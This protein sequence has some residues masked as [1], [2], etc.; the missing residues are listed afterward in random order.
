MEEIKSDPTIDN[1]TLENVKKIMSE[2][3]N[4][5]LYYFGTALDV[6][7]HYFF[8]LENDRMNNK[9]LSFPKGGGLSILR[10]KEW[11]FEPEEY[12]K[13]RHNGDAEFYQISGYSIYAIC[14]SCVD[15]RPGCKSVFFTEGY[16]DKEDL[17]TII[18][19]RPNAKAI[20][21][22]MP[23]QIGW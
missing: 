6:A 23:F 3:T 19:S 8:K 16:I 9:G 20:I 18:L 4:P 7:G 5:S 14:G 11:P 21:E 10:V 13:S 17:K 2:K 1:W 12:P 22:K 15:R